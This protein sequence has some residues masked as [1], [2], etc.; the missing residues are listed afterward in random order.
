MDTY[1]LPFEDIFAS[2]AGG[3]VFSKLDLTHAYLQI[4]LDEESK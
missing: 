4:L 3:T 2:L 1:P